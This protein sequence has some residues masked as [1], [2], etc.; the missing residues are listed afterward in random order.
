M[1]LYMCNYKKITIYSVVTSK[2]KSMPQDNMLSALQFKRAVKKGC[3]PLLIHFKN[4]YSKE[5][6]SR[7]ENNLVRS[8]L[9]EY[10]DVC[11]PVYAGLP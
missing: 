11:Q 7:L 10:E 3:T 1:Y 2:N 4:V 5:P 8:L 9:K 6:S